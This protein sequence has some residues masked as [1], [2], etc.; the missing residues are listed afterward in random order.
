MASTM[1]PTSSVAGS[2]IATEG[3]GPSASMRSTARSVRSSRRR[4]SAVYS[5]RSLKLTRISRDLSPMTWALVTTRP[6]G[7]TTTPEPSTG[8]RRRGC[9][10]KKRSRKGSAAWGCRSAPS[11][12]TSWM[13]TT[14]GAA[15]FTTGAKVSLISAKEEGTAVVGAGVT[16]AFVSA[17]ARAASGVNATIAASQIL[18]AI[19]PTSTC[20]DRTP[21]RDDNPVDGVS[22]PT[23]QGKAPSGVVGAGRRA[24]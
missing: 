7:S 16:G 15:R 21:M 13:L 18:S 19:G 9:G 23:P 2:P 20:C 4:S 24:A 6:E 1:S 3:N 12:S 22:A 5:R 8:P 14:A 17:C 10:P 11:V